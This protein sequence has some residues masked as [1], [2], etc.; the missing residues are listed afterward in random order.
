M[1]VKVVPG[2]KKWKIH[3]SK[4]SLISAPGLLRGLFGPRAREVLEYVYLSGKKNLFFYQNTYF[5]LVDGKPAGL[6]LVYAH[7]QK[8]GT[9]FPMARDFLK[10]GGPGMVLQAKYIMKADKLMAPTKKGQSYLN[11]FGVY[12]QY[13][14]KG[15][16]TAIME[17]VFKDAKKKGSTHIILD[18]ETE[19]KIAM[20]F[21]YKLGFKKM[22]EP[23]VIPTKAKSHEFISLKKKL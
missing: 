11:N 4:L 14:D 6:A 5:G 21:Y 16:G 2:Q 7:E 22:G 20:R 15:V 23:Y 8:S 18:V 13:R 19:N 12:Q 10:A 9:W 1:S 3:F 17:H